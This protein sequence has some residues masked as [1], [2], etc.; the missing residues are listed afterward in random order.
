MSVSSS[1]PDRLTVPFDPVTLPDD[2]A[3]LDTSY[4]DEMLKAL[5][6]LAKSQV[7][8]QQAVELST[9]HVQR[10]VEE[11]REAME[12]LR[13]QRDEAQAQVERLAR[14]AAEVLGLVAV[15]HAGTQAGGS[16]ELRQAAETL[17]SAVAPH[18]ERAGLREVPALGEVPD[19]L[20]HYALGNRPART[21]A[22]RGRIV[23]V[24]RPGYLFGT[25]ILRKADVIVAL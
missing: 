19:T 18:A 25:Q 12:A 16:S 5:M 1:S 3:P 22:E 7:R 8:T 20:Y 11:S 2:P 15:F 14:F 23:E 21:D 13:T 10:A 17:R 6:R 4:A 24:V 9:E